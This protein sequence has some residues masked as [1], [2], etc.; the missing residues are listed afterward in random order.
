MVLVLINIIIL[1]KE[2]KKKYLRKSEKKKLSEI[3]NLFIINI[4]KLFKEKKSEK[5]IK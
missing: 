1:K 3:Q 5:F 4:Y 2:V